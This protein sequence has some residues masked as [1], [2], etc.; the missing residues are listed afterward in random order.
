MRLND[1]KRDDWSQ[2]GEDGVIEHI[3]NVIGSQHNRCM[4]FGAWDG[5]KM[6]NS[7]LWWKRHDWEAILVELDTDKFGTLVANT[8]GRKTENHNFAVEPT[9]DHSV[10]N[11]LHGRELDFISIDVDGD[12]WLIWEGMKSKPRVVVIEYNSSIPLGVVLAQAKGEYFG[13]SAQVVLDIAKNKGYTLVEM[14][15]ANCFF[16]RDEYAPLFSAFEAD[17]AKLFDPCHLAYVVSAYDRRCGLT[18]NESSWGSFDRSSG[19]PIQLAKGTL[20]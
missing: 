6:S 1:Y 10:D 3:F 17:P 15:H 12:D 7:A 11:I 14:N 2:F 8:A 9:G 5:F 19:K 4:E 13:A 16:V 20:Y 18:R